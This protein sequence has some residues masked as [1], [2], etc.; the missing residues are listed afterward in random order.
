MILYFKSNLC[1]AETLESNN[2]FEKKQLILK[3]KAF[4]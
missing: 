3:N 4:T 1:I 2:A